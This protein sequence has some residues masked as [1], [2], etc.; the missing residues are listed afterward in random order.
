MLGGVR[1]SGTRRSWW[2]REALA[3]EPAELVAATPPLSR[4]PTADVVIVGG[5]YTGL[6]TAWRLTELEPGAR[7]VILE[8]DICGGGPSG[9]NGGF[10]TGWWDELP[11]LVERYGPDGALA[12]ARAIDEAVDEIGAWCRA[13]DVDAWYTKAGA[14]SVSAAP[15]QDAAW[16]EAVEACRELGVG[17]EYA[18]LGEDEVRSRVASPV[19]RG[20]V[21]HARRGDDPAGDPGARPAPGPARPRRDD[22]RGDTGRGARRRAAGRAGR[23]WARPG[24]RAPAGPRSGARSGF[25]P[26]RRSAT[27]R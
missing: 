6:W 10:V 14:L 18:R 26:S 22:P 20:G 3:A 17:E 19:F 8:A 5:G 11:T 23:G 1:P 2:L 16:D 25:G 4:K 12:T 24:R 21:L 9:R 7:I 27:A 13:N 15:A